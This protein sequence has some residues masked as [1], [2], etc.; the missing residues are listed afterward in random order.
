[1]NFIKFMECNGKGNL[2]IVYYLIFFIIFVFVLFYVL[3]NVYIGLLGVMLMGYGDGFV[4]VFGKKYGI[5]DIGYGKIVVGVVIMFVVLL[6]VFSL[7]IIYLNSVIRF[8]IVLVVVVFVIL[9][10]YL[11]FK[12][13]DNLFVLLGILFLYYVLLLI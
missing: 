11:I 8:W 9:I 1:M 5:K 13:L 12:G 2:G 3:G 7:I 4:V 6:F 10:E